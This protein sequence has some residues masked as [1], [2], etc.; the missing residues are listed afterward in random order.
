V[1]QD[2]ETI[3]LDAELIQSR[4]RRCLDIIREMPGDPT[5]EGAVAL[6]TEY[7]GR[8]ALDFAY[9]E[10]AGAYRDALHAA[11]LRVI[12]RAIRIDLKAG[13][14]ERGTFIAERAAEI[15]PEAEEIQTALIR[16]YQLSGAHAAAAE[17]Y[18]H[19]KRSM[20]DLGLE[21]KP[22]ADV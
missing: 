3:W 11:Y 13:H 1:G 9:E 19:Y 17:Q 8:F 18:G 12:E 20:R 14:L 22:F 6:A 5:P 2:G 21:P 10:W 7:R 16:L 15:D 4:S